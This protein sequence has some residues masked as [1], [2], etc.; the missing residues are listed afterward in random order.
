MAAE[1]QAEHNTVWLEGMFIAPQHFQQHDRYQQSL[2]RDWFSSR[3]GDNWGLKALELDLAQFKVGRIR[4]LAAQ[5]VLPDGTLFSLSEELSL[6]IPPGSIN[7]QVYLAIPLYR[8]GQVNIARDAAPT[9]RYTSF[10]VEVVD[11]AS[12]DNDVLAVEQCRLNL[13]LQLEG[14]DLSCFSLVPLVVIREVQSDGSLILDSS[15]VPPCLDISVSSV[16][17]DQRNELEALMVQRSRQ[18]CQRLQVGAQTKSRQMR[19]LD[20]LWLQTLNRW[21]PWFSAC[22][23]MACEDIFRE[24]AMCLGD[25]LALIQEP[26]P[27][28]PVFDQGNPGPPML[29]LFRS[30]R[31]VLSSA[32]IDRVLMLD[33]DKS[34]FSESRLLK[35]QDAGPERLR[36]GRMIL[37]VSSSLGLVAIGQRFINASKMAGSRR[38]VSLVCSALPGI[39]MEQ[40][41]VAPAELQAQPDMVYYEIDGSDP[42]WK[43]MVATQDQLTMHVD[44]RFPDITLT[45]FVIRQGDSL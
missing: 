3:C 22:S 39:R 34:E 37:G 14:A 13:S 43:E 4:V 29:V 33:W 42:L 11:E 15:F 44:E 36:E 18:A 17:K 7:K 10:S 5:G 26:L 32:A 25:I 20:L 23:H 30:L 41:S 19:V 24:L 2:I 1:H 8:R 28:L 12:G 35:L 31:H 21:L 45:L 9:V 16:L 27:E 38:I 6:Q 40:M